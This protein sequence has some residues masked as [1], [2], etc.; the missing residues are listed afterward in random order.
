MT[1]PPAP[2]E[3]PAVS[4]PSEYAPTKITL[5]RKAA[6]MGP[7]KKVGIA[8]LGGLGVMA[9][10]SYSFAC[11]GRVTPRRAWFWPGLSTSPPCV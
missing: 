4:P 1:L 2:L 5:H 11:R 3:S 9:P 7:G 10:L 8:G 6:G